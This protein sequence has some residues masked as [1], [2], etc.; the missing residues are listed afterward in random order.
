MLDSLESWQTYDPVMRGSV[1]FNRKRRDIHTMILSP[2]ASSFSKGPRHHAGQC[3]LCPVWRWRVSHCSNG[4][5]ERSDKGVE[6]GVER[7]DAIHGR[8]V[9]GMRGLLKK[10]R[11]E[12]YRKGLIVG[13]G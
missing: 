10:G 6:G 7:F 3:S 11:R 4:V 9:N 8:F 13:V 2:A 12:M 1:P 5:V